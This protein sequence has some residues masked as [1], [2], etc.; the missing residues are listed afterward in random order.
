MKQFISFRLV[1]IILLSYV[2]VGYGCGSKGGTTPP[3]PNPCAGVTIA[4]TATTT[5]PTT[6]SSNGSITASASGGA[7]GFT[8]SINGSAFQPSGNFLNLAA[9]SHSIVAK[10]AEG[11]TGSASFTLTAVNPCTGVTITVTGTTVNP[12]TTLVSNGSI[13]ATAAGSSGFTFSLNSGIPQASGNFSGLAVGTYTVVARD[14]NGC[15]GSTVFTLT[16]PNPCA[17]ITINVTATTVNPTSVVA[18]NGSISASATGSSGF[19]FNINGGAF[20]GTGN[21]TNL[22]QGT[23]TIVAKDLNGCTGSAAFTLTAPNPCAG[24]TVTFSSVVTNNTP[25]QAANGT[26]TLTGAGGTGPYMFSM[27]T[28]AF[29]TA[30]LFSGLAA[31]S[32]SFVTRDVNNCVSSSNNVVVNNLAAGPL[33]QAV[34]SLIQANCVSCHNPSNANGGMILSVDCNIVTN[35]DRVRIRAVDGNPSAMPP[36]GLLPASERLKITN[37]INAGGRF[38]D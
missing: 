6:G 35:K 14:L 1:S 15:T 24:V 38:T 27:N 7:S 33:F 29:Q 17:G 18:T 13:N 4:V 30:N 2:M 31:A 26:I 23:Y 16:A 20:Q 36:S 34:Q 8:Y 37:W 25:C 9:G 28:G 5:N 12:T 10:N 19:T 21:F 32:Y 11:C 22:A 3:P